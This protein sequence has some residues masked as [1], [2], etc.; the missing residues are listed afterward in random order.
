MVKVMPAVNA[1]TA[2][3]CSLVLA[4]AVGRDHGYKPEYINVKMG[5]YELRGVLLPVQSVAVDEQRQILVLR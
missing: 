5:L 2:N 1:T 4:L 3:T